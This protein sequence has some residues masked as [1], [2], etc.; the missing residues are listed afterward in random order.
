VPI[1]RCVYLP[2]GVSVEPGGHLII[3][4]DDVYV[5]LSHYLRERE[6]REAEARAVP[7]DNVT[8]LSFTEPP[9]S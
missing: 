4:D 1:P 2:D 6:A 7:R 5:S 3:G 8:A 9:R